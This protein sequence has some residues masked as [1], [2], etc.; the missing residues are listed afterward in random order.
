MTTSILLQAA[1]FATP[2]HAD[3]WASPVEV[4]VR[5]GDGTFSAR[6]VPESKG[7]TAHL[8]RPDG[9]EHTFKLQNEWAPVD[10][11]LL[12]GGTLLCFDQWHS[13]GLGPVLTVYDS[14]GEVLLDRT[15]EQLMP[16]VDLDRI[17]RSVSSRWWRKTPL[18]YEVVAG[19]KPETVLVTLWDE[20]KLSIDISTGVGKV[21]QVAV[22]DDPERLVNRA[23]SL[24]PDQAAEGVALLDR[25]LAVDP[26]H[27]RSLVARADLQ[28]RIDRH[29]DVIDQLGPILDDLVANPPPDQGYSVANLAV[30]LS[31]SFTELGK[32]KDAE[33]ALR[34]VLFV[35][36]S[37]QRPVGE[38]ARLLHDQG[39][40]DEVDE[41]LKR[42]LAQIPTG[43]RDMMVADAARIYQEHGRLPEARDTYL[44]LHSDQKVTGMHAYIELAGLHEKLG[45]TDRA[46]A[47]HEQLL[48]HYKSM[49]GDAWGHYIEQSNKALARLR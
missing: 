11:V 25:A 22:A 41:L 17:S 7:S 9:K 5:S 30:S 44:L 35:E 36:P 45:E 31:Q 37:Y 49:G 38:L 12:D 48:R 3:E 39:R 42:W 46:I 29:S 1:L 43:Y 32:A 23:E 26:R 24:P 8:T 2:A 10:V 14:Q 40:P 15:L 18:E 47:V 27:M 33:K 21:V 4:E 20:N 34:K 16:G 6:I 13:L 19:E 28:Q